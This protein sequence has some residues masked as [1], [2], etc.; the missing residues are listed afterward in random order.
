MLFS[1][2][3]SFANFF[4]DVLTLFAFVVWFWLAISVFGDL[5]RRRD[6][7]GWGKTLW[8]MGVIVFPYLGVFVYLISQANAWPNAV[9]SGF[10]RPE[11]NL[12]MSLVSA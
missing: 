3:F 8:V 6:V 2:G 1:G 10:S 12:E 7:S 4:M 5:F 9:S 11:K